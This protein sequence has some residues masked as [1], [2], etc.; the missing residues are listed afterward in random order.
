[1]VSAGF[2]LP[3]VGHTLPSKVKRLGTAKERRFASTT[4]SCSDAAV[5]QPPMKC[6]SRLMVMASA[7]PAA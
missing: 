4:P 5:R 7:A 2:A 1:M 3:C 6:A